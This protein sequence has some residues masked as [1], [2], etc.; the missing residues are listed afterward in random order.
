MKTRISWREKL[1]RVQ[2]PKIV[3]IPPKMQKRFGRGKMLIPRPLDVDALI[4]KVPR[5]KLVTQE[6]LRKKLA[7][8]A[9]VEVACPI[10]TGIFVRISAEAANEAARAGKSRVTPYWR[11]IRESG[12][13]M[14]KLPGG[15]LAQADHLESEGHAIDR[16]GKLRVI[17]PKRAFLKFQ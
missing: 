9:A 6:Q 14:E 8:D 16:S 3:T 4:R 2:D 10:C 15:P 17:D 7:A 11:V 13:L 12:V 1:E 5:G